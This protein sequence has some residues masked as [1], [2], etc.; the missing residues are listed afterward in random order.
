M[1]LFDAMI[2]DFFGADPFIHMRPSANAMTRGD[3]RPGPRNTGSL[4]G[5]VPGPHAVRQITHMVEGK[6]RGVKG[7]ES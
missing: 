3:P 4:P 7:D 2:R 5:G 6:T 1:S